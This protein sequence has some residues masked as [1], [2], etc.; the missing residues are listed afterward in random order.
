LERAEE[1]MITFDNAVVS[2][3]ADPKIRSSSV[4]KGMDSG[5]VT[6]VSKASF[7]YSE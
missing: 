4:K 5:D 7:T 2:R 3:L 6:E 1:K